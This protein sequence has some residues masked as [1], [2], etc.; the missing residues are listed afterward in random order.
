MK[1][2]LTGVVLLLAMTI[3]LATQRATLWYMGHFAE[4]GDDPLIDSLLTLTIAG[5][6]LFAALYIIHRWRR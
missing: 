2:P 6:A 1:L 4:S 5:G 3:G